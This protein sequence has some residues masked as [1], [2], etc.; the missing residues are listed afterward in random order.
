MT[1]L[2]WD[3]DQLTESFLH[4]ILVPGGIVAQ[5][6]VEPRLEVTLSILIIVLEGGGDDELYDDQSQQKRFQRGARL[7]LI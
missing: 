5:D 1:D 4:P 7:M 6:Q 2:K 3:L